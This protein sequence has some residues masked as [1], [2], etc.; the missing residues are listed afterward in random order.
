MYPLH[1]DKPHNRGIHPSIQP[2]IVGAHAQ[3]HHRV[4]ILLFHP[5]T[6]RHFRMLHRISRPLRFIAVGCTAAV[7][8]WLTVV[9]LVEQ[10]GLRPL[11]ANVFGWLVAVG[12]SFAGHHHLT[13][14]GHGV[15]LRHSA[16]RFVLLSAIGFLINES[17][18]AISLHWSKLGYQLLLTGVLLGVAGITWVLS[19]VWVFRDNP[20]RA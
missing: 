18:Y 9:G 7:V 11:Q 6:H 8:H 19:H 16:R 3:R 13:F 2:A 14:R 12:V 20:A 4:A 1:F 17:A 15:P 5:C 10:T